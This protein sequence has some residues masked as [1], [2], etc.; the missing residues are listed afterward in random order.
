[1]VSGSSIL[2]CVRNSGLHGAILAGVYKI[3]NKVLYVF[4]LLHYLNQFSF[5]LID[6]DQDCFV[7]YSEV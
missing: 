4:T 7:Y 3:L 5:E 1:V 2:S 6:A